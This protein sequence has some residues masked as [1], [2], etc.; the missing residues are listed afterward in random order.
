MKS[1]EI[2]HAEQQIEEVRRLWAEGIESGPGRFADMDGIIE[3]A[4]KRFNAAPEND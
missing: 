4:Q 3:E 1:M 2:S